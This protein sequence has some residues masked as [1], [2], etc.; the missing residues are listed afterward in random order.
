M[1]FLR[2]F[3]KEGYLKAVNNLPDYKIILGATAYF[4]KGILTENDLK[5]INE[6]LNAENTAEEIENL[7]EEVEGENV[8]GTI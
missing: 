5:E 3:I 6:A 2:N 4:D 1:D 8:D 7:N